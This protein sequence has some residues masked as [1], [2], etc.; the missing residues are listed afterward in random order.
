MEEDKTERERNNNSIIK[1]EEKKF[2]VCEN[3][4]IASDNVNYTLPDTYNHTKVGLILRDPA[5]AFAYWELKEQDR[6]ELERAGASNRLVLRVYEKD[7]DAAAAGT[8]FDIPVT[9]KDRGWYFNLPSPDKSYHIDLLLKGSVEEKFLCR[10]NKISSPAKAVTD[11]AADILGKI[12]DNY[13]FTGL[14][15]NSELEDEKEKPEDIPQ[16]IISMFDTEYILR[17]W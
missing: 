15:E 8:S 7:I 2:E 13:V 14:Y 12:H 11:A 1:I 6:E 4:E 3:E 16:R 10:S 17:K 9:A 5:W